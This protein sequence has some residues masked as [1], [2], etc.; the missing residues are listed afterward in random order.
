MHMICCVLLCIRYYLWNKALTPPPKNG[1][2]SNISDWY[3]S[4]QRNVLYYLENL[5]DVQ[6]IF[7]THFWTL[8]S[9]KRNIKM[10]VILCNFQQLTN[11]YFINCKNENHNFMKKMQMASKAKNCRRKVYNFHSLIHY[12]LCFI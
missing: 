7:N 6:K 9:L 12:W 8:M 3:Y 1:V 5:K 11:G 10:S 4:V 2:F